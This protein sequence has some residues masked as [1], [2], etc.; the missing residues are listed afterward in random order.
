MNWKGKGVASISA[1]RSQLKVQRKR[2]SKKVQ[3][4]KTS[5][6]VSALERLG[7]MP[8]VGSIDS[9]AEAAGISRGDAYRLICNMAAE[10]HEPAL[11]LVSSW[12]EHPKELINSMSID[13]L[14]RLAGKRPTAVLGYIVRYITSHA[15]ERAG[16]KAAS[17]LP[18]IVD[19]TIASSKQLGSAGLEDR[20]ILLKQQK[21]IVEEPKGALVSIDQRQVNVTA[22]PSEFERILKGAMQRPELP[23]ANVY[24]GVVV[25][26]E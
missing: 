14:C 6:A 9:A 20:K 13:D 8:K 22:G 18:D 21:F 19:A 11:A 2:R 26:S 23:P 5:A 3:I 16:L 10:G 12:A 1:R 25:E 4:A 17:A 7:A 24:E 15:T